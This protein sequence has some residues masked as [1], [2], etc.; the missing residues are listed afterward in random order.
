MVDLTRYAEIPYAERGRS[1]DGCD[2]YGLAILVLR[3][4]FGVALPDV[5]YDTDVVAAY[6]THK[7]TLPVEPVDQPFDGA[8]IDI[9]W[10][11]AHIG[12][13]IDGYVLHTSERYGTVCQSWGAIQQRVRGVYRVV[14]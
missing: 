4:E 6:N 8:I 3:H 1:F 5:W 14:G 13:Y 10:P 2:C 9:R 7:S 12:V 11:T